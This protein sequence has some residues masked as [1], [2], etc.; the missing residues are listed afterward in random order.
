[1]YYNGGTSSPVIITTDGTY[2]VTTTDDWI[3]IEE[4]DNTFTV[5]VTKNEGATKRNGKVVVN[6]TGL[7]E[8]ES[9]TREVVIEQNPKTDDIE[10]EDWGDTEDWDF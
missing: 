6:V 1:M 9:L 2:T 3:T 5:T 4:K 8:G 7:P 10:V